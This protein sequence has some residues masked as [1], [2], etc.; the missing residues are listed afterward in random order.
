MIP[1]LIGSDPSFLCSFW[2]GEANIDFPADLLF[3]QFTQQTRSP[4]RLILSSCHDF[5]QQL[6]VTDTN[7]IPIAVWSHIGKLHYLSAVHID[8]YSS[9]C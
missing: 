5:S 4:A 8:R 7:Q 6:S 2:S 3:R 1:D 9:I